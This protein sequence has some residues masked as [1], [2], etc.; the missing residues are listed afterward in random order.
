M[1]NK[2]NHILLIALIALI[3]TCPVLAQNT[4]KKK[5]RIQAEYFKDHNRSESIVATLKIKEDSYVPYSDAE[6]HFYSISDTSKI[7]LDKIKTDKEG[8]AIYLMEDPQK[9]YKDSSGLMTFEFEYNGDSSS[10]GANKDLEIKQAN[11]KISFFQED[12][13]KYIAVEAKEIEADNTTIPIEE[14]EISLY[15]K[16]TFSLLNINKEETDEEGKVMVEF[17]VEMPG[18]TLGILTIVAKIE[19]S[20][21]YGSVVSQGVINWGQPV[22]LKAEKH[23]GL[24]DTDAPLWMVYTLIILLSAVWFHYLYVIFLIVKIKLSRSSIT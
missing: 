6:I 12:S 2:Y 13:I 8:K 11:L 20:D 15:I 16:G 1:N 18:D 14:L 3:A 4:E 10:K 21:I 22:A 24:G 19:E 7:L 5:T 9:I 17:P 23:R